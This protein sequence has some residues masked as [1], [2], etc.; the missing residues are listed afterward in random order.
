VSLRVD[1]EVSDAQA[2]PSTLLSSCCLLIHTEMQL[3]IYHCVLSCAAM[4]PAMMT[5]D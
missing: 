5:V 1:F 3:F 4:L 2:R